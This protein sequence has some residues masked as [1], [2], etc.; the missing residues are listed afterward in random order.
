MYNCQVIQ[1]HLQNTR[2]KL[3][4][5]FQ[6]WLHSIHAKVLHIAGKTFVKPEI[7]PPWR[8]NQITWPQEKKLPLF[9]AP[10]KIVKYFRTK[11]LMS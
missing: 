11:P 10:H 8:R 9:M 3:L 5:Q 4:K 7:S 1:T 6:V 2:Y